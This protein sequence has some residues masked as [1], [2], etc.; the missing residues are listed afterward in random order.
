MILNR[1]MLLLL[2]VVCLLVLTFLP[3]ISSAQQP[4]ENEDRIRVL[5][6]SS[7]S[8]AEKAN[9]EP[10]LSKS[11]FSERPQG[12]TNITTTATNV[13]KTT[14]IVGGTTAAQG[15]YPFFAIPKTSAYG[16][17]LC[18]SV[19]IWDDVLLTAAHCQGSF[20]G[21]IIYIGGNRRDGSDA[22]EVARGGTE[23]VHPDFDFG[24]IQHDFMLVKLRQRTTKTPNAK[25]NRNTTYPTANQLATVIGFGV[26]AESGA[27]VSERL[28]EVD[29][30]VKDTATCRAAYRSEFYPSSMLCASL[31][32]KDSCQ[33]DR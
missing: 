10:E 9:M 18:G 12:T 8:A 11:L 24:T 15:A 27:P 28:L 21:K 23:L 32:N 13:T 7:R 14:R 20:A 22:L 4:Q 6:R 17:G 16:V 19:K 26:T 30:K 1:E 25:Y 33:G 5:R 3:V 31:R 2:E 29:I